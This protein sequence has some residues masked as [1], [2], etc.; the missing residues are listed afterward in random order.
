MHARL[1]TRKAIISTRNPTLRRT[2]IYMSAF[3]G[4]AA[5]YLARDFIPR[6]VLYAF[7][8]LLL[9]FLGESLYMIIRYYAYSE[10]TLADL[11][12][13]FSRKTGQKIIEG[14]PA[15]VEALKRYHRMKQSNESLE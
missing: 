15:P 10:K 5:G 6:P 7:I 4:T 13:A 1:F 2:I 3:L 14:P 9:S 11:E 8:A 12:A